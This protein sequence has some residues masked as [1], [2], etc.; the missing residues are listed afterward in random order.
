MI[1]QRGQ[2]TQMSDTIKEANDVIESLVYRLQQMQQELN[3]A[4][5]R[6]ES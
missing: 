3:K 4:Q 2:M 5:G 1:E 6:S